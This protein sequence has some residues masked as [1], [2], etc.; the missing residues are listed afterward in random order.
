MRVSLNGSSAADPVK[1]AAETLPTATA[2]PGTA[3]I[4][5]QLTC[6]DNKIDTDV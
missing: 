6:A 3:L 4:T 2:I 5:T 1:D